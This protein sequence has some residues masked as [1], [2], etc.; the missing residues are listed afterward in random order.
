[1]L[2]CLIE[3]FRILRPHYTASH[4]ESVRWLSSAH[5]KSESVLCGPDFAIEPFRRSLERHITRFGC[6]PESLGSRGHDLEDFLHL[7]WERMRIF[8]LDKDA[9][10]AG[11]YARMDVFSEIANRVLE[12]F[13]PEGESAPTEM[14]HVTCTGYVAPSAAQK[15]VVRRGWQATVAVMHAYHMGCYAS[16][17]ALRMATAFL[18]SPRDIRVKL[19]EPNYGAGRVDIVHTETCTLHLDPS[20]HSPEQLVV[21]SLFSDGH[22]RYSVRQE[23]EVSGA[24]G[25]QKAR[26]GLRFLGVHEEIISGSLG[27]M[28]WIL[29]DTG[30]KM[31]LARDVPELIT[32]ALR[33]F[34][35]RLMERC[36]I[37]AEEAFGS[38]L[39][40][41][42]PGG[43]R[44]IDR[45]AEILELR[46]EQ[47]SA[48]RAV[49][50]AYG[51]M[52]SATLP[53]VWAAMLEDIKVAS[54]TLITSLAFGPGL[55]VY[56]A[57]L[58]KV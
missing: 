25:N 47:V 39:F 33:N 50:K 21:Q 43:P 55:T 52:S 2:N 32:G 38:G 20:Q 4:E 17:P 19:G 13:F 16:M 7:E 37:A 27:A 30:M 42:H 29:G 14:I 3:D 49:L 10:G 23:N 31:I 54:G 6:G 44:I 58:R 45:V 9:R 56:G 51:N 8:N 15:L 48:S 5:A 35:R 40:A 18:A 26:V 24:Q 57:V 36:G 41:I 12:T 28:G 11:M 53:H 46:P 1:M 22:I 34:L